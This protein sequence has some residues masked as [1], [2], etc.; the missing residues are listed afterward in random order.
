MHGAC[1]GGVQ[2]SPGTARSCGYCTLS[3]VWI[4]RGHTGGTRQVSGPEIVAY[5]LVMLAAVVRVMLPLAVPMWL[6]AA[7][8]IAGTAWAAAFGIYLLVS[9]PWLIKT[10]LDGK[11]G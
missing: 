7:L 8:V 3:Y 11:D 9:S 4:P 10:R 5:M 2:R 6:P 1:C